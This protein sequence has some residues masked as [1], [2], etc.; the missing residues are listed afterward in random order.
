MKIARVL[1]GIVVNIEVA[2]PEWLT[3]NSAGSDGSVLVPYEDSDVVHIGLGW[4]AATGFE[5]P[6]SEDA[7][8]TRALDA[9][10][11]DDDQ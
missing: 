11:A 9:L 10:V 8:L 2:S 4:S 1:D 6:P 5:Q 3:D 7:E